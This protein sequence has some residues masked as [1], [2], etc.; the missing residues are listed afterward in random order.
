VFP[1]VPRRRGLLGLA[2]LFLAVA[3]FN[4]WLSGKYYRIGYA[5]STALEE[6]Q[7]LQKEQ[8]LLNTEILTLKSPA[9]IEAIA[10]D[11]LGMVDPKTDR[12]VRVK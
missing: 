1:P 5:V 7:V 9:R 10:R 2:V 8:A 4:V 12:I 3:L 11:Q 6:K